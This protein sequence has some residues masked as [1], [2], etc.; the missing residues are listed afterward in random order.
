MGAANLPGNFMHDVRFAFRT[1][2]QHP[3]FSTVVVLT[4]ALGIGVNTAIFSLVNAIL[5]RPL[6]FPHSEELVRIWDRSLPY[7]GF[8]ELHGRLRNMEVATYA[9][10]SG[11]NLTLNGEASRVVAD[12]TSSN[13]FSVLQ[14][15]PMLGRDFIPEDK[16]GRHVIISYSLWQNQFSGD[17]RIIGRNI[18]L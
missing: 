10:E 1:I 7:G 17:P 13:L 18:I 6:G 12:A 11:F 3:A 9:H 4:L 16:T 8:V 5:L 2:I 15:K 14:V